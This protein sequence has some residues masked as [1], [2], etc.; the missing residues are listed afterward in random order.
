M[1][2][3]LFLLKRQY[4]NSLGHQQQ[5]EFSVVLSHGF[6]SP[7][8]ELL[9]KD[10]RRRVRGFQQRHVSDP[11]LCFIDSRLH[12]KSHGTQLLLQ[13]SHCYM[14]SVHK[15][16]VQLNIVPQASTLFLTHPPLFLKK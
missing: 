1:D 7:D 10:G 11:E 8:H 16:D 13:D 12:S 4:P 5:N 2:H 15:W 3:F 6:V 14:K 9:E